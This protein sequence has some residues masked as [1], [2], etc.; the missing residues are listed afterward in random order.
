R[1]GLKAFDGAACRDIPVL[2]GIMADGT[3]LHSRKDDEMGHVCGRPQKYTSLSY[4]VPKP[5][6]A[7]AVVVA[8]NAGSDY[9]FVPDDNSDAVRAAVAIKPKASVNELR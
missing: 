1:D 6:P 2:S 7:G 3:H 9:L 8:A 4:A 5:L